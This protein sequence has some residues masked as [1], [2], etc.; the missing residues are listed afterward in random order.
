MNNNLMVFNNDMFEVAVRIENG[1]YVFDAE[2]VAVSLGI[3]TVAKSGNVC[4]RWSRV[5]EYL[6]VS[7]QVGKG[8]FIPEPAVYKL[9]FKANN[10]VAEKFQDWL[11][12]DVLP[13]IRQTGGYI[14]VKENDSDADIMAKAL[15]IAQK[16][17]DLKEKALS[18]QQEV[19]KELAPKAEAYDDL[20]D[21]DKCIDVKALSSILK[22]KEGKRVLGRNKLFEK[23]RKEGILNKYNVPYQRCIEAGYFTTII[24][25]EGF[26]KTLVTPKGIEYLRKRLS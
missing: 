3:T 11:A 7:P 16:T 12:V 26:T 20:M 4:V 18:E 17:L 1:E 24:T 13:Q 10:E 6:K 14:P 23:L 19:I 2:K 15:L 5:N 8:D 25:R 22:I 21:S 9:A